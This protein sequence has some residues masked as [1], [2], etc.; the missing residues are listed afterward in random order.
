MHGINPRWLEVFKA[1]FFFFPFLIYSNR[2]SFART[3]GHYFLCLPSPSLC[4][5]L[6]LFPLVSP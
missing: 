5:T 2:L 4:H 3:L 6:S 1:L